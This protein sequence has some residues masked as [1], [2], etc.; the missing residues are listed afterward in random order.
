[1]RI[2]IRLLVCTATEMCIIS[3][4]SCRVCTMGREGLADKCPDWHR[5]GLGVQKL[6]G[7]HVICA[8]MLYANQALSA[9]G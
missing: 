3:L 8:C 6:Q 4:S 7:L 1:V 5:L 2:L 9:G